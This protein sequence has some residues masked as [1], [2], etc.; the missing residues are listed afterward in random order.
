MKEGVELI[1]MNAKMAR[2]LM[3]VSVFLWWNA[4]WRCGFFAAKRTSSGNMATVLLAPDKIWREH[5]C[6][7]YFLALRI[8]L[9]RKQY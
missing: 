6:S 5:L 7:E 4:L 1:I 9:R 8:N 3:N 2:M